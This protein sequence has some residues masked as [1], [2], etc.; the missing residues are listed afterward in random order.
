[1]SLRRVEMIYESISIRKAVQMIE[2][3]KLLLPHIQRPFVWRQDRGNNQVRRFMDSIMREYPFGTLLFWR[4]RDDIQ[5]RRFVEDYKDGMNIKSTYI[6][7]TDFADREKTLVLDGQQRL[8]TLYTALK[9]TYN[10][11]EMYFQYP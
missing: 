1:M 8:Q 10:G 7:S 11:K 3:K 6:K 4:T 2:E 5:L 9:G